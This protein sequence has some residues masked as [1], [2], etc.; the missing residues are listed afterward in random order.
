MAAIR[1]LISLI[2]FQSVSSVVIECPV[3]ECPAPGS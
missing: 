1:P 3:L 2:L